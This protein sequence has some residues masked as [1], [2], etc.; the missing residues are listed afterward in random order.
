MRRDQYARAAWTDTPDIYLTAVRALLR[1]D[2]AVV[3]VQVTGHVYQPS[4]CLFASCRSRASM[5][6]KWSSGQYRVR[7]G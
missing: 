1:H 4:P 2:L 7:H 6:K 5:L 3:R